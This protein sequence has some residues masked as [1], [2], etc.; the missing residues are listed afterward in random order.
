MPGIFRRD[1]DEDLCNP[2]GD[3]RIQRIKNHRPIIDREELFRSNGGRWEESRARATSE[4]DSLHSSYKL[5]ISYKYTNYSTFSMRINLIP[6][7]VKFA[8]I[9]N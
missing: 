2:R 7:C 6:F 9:P 1:D 8:R 3:E 5:Q 4:D